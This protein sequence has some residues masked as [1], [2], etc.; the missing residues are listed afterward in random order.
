MDD[1]KVYVIPCSGIGKATASVGR[2]ATYRVVED[3]RPGCA[4]TICLGLLTLGDEEAEAKLQEADVITIDGCA[5]D[6]ARKNVEASGKPPTISHRVHDYLKEH[7]DLK[8]ET[9]LDIGEGGRKLADVI[10]ADIAEEIDELRNECG[11]PCA[12]ED[13]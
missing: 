8:P 3:E 7:R 5:K 6:C 1:R 11:D 9:V 4:D 10:A 12:G 2:E 13:E